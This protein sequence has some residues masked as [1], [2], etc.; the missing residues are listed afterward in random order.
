MNSKTIKFI[1]KTRTIL[2]DGEKMVPKVGGFATWGDES[3]GARL[4]ALNLLGS[5]VHAPAAFKAHVKFTEEIISQIPK[6]DYELDESIV[7]KWI[8]K[9]CRDK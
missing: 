5:Y 4:T 1:Y 6:R 8:V 7:A 3:G 9:N 2:I